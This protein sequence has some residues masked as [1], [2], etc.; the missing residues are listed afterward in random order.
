[1]DQNVVDIVKSTVPV[2]KERGIEI[3]EKFYELLF[4]NH[5]ELKGLFNEEKQRNGEQPKAL[6]MSI[7]AAAKNIDNLEAILPTVKKIGEVHV[8]SKVMPE[9]YP[10]VGET[11][12]LA[13]K[14]VLGE[15]IDDNFLNAWS[16]AYKFISNIFINIEN[17]IRK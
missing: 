4:K 16:Q 10:I 1:M 8:N 9:H 13:F 14:E 6:A 12:L 11:L 17:D 3:T 15:E 7:L 5:S 2:L